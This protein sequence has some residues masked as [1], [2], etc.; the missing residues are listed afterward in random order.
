MKLWKTIPLALTLGLCACDK[1]TV[2]TCETYIQGGLSA[3]STYKRI[4]VQESSVPITYEQLLALGKDPRMVKI[5]KDFHMPAESLHMVTISYDAQ[6]ALGV[7]LRSKQICTFESDEPA[8]AM[9]AA[10]LTKAQQKQNGSC[11]LF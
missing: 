4:A 2:K 8:Q 10:G 1:E 3:P 9:L 5:A 7:P 11:C 6:N